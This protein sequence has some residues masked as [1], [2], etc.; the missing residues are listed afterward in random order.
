ME[1]PAE[2]THGPS[3][4]S[5][6]RAYTVEERLAILERQ[7]LIFAGDLQQIKVSTIGLEQ[8]R[9]DT[10]TIRE[11]LEG[12]RVAFSVIKWLVRT[13]KFLGSIAIAIAAMW[14]VYIAWRTGNLPATYRN[15]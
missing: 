4:P 14:G 1:T 10:A 13:I 3:G 15:P 8:V 7:H 6:P 2:I 9:I 12:S 11:I 5:G